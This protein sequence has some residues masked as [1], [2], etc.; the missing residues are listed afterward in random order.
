M[1]LQKASYAATYLHQ[2]MLRN[3]MIQD[4]S[5][6]IYLKKVYPDLSARQRPVLHFLR[7]A[8]VPM[9]N[10][11]IAAG[12][13][14]PINHITPRVLELREK[15]LVLESGRRR[16]KVTGNTAKTWV[17]KYPV[18]PPAFKEIAPATEKG[19]KCPHAC[20]WP[21]QKDHWHYRKAE[22]NQQPLGI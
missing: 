21:H 14:L 16:C 20:P 19:G 9:T 10:A 7:T 4:T 1:A 11:E 17:A 3:N 6:E 2:I 13:Q 22:N 8:S 18:L 15:T 12:M 5:L